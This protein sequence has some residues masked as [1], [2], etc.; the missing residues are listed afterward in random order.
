MK[1]RDCGWPKI[2]PLTAAAGVIAKDSVSAEPGSLGVE[3]VEQLLLLAVVRA[4]RVAERRPDA[5]E[6]LGVQVLAASAAASGSNQPRRASQVDVLGERLGEPVGQRLD[7]DR[8]VVVVLRLV[9]RRELLGAVDRD[10]EAA[11]VVAGRRDVV[12]EAAVRA[13]V[14]GFAVCC[15]SIGKRTPSVEHDVV[16][17]G[18]RRPEAVRRRGA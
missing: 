1:Y 15:R 10:R 6:A 9:A 14:A 18:V 2:S 7:H 3:Q 13:R 8:P 16:A 4:G 17:L 11:E 12:G 5:A